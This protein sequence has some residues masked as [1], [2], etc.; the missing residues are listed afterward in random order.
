[1]NTANTGSSQIDVLP[2]KSDP[3]LKR[4]WDEQRFLKL[5]C[6]AILIAVGL[7]QGWNARHRVFTDGIS[8]LEIA[9]YYLAG[10]WKAALS[11]YWSPLYSW[12]LALWML[13]L[14]PSAYWEGSL[15]HL[16][17]FV[18]YVASLIAFEQ[19]LTS[20]FKLRNR[21][22]ATVVYPSGRSGWLAIAL[23]RSARSLLSKSLVFR[24]TWWQ[25]L[26]ACF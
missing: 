18:A 2:T 25:Q 7:L 14:H 21:L 5:T 12:V 9:R 16:T 11:S 4:E 10:D 6:W 8:Y 3:D 20:L 19:L 26:S 15:L 23:S 22:L 24:Q 1:M 17:N 13:I